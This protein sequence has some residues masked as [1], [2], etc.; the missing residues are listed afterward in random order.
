LESKT[1]VVEDSLFLR[2]FSSQ[3]PQRE[4]FFLKKKK[5]K[6]KKKFVGAI[7]TTRMGICS[8]ILTHA[9]FAQD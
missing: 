7:S 2:T 3:F 6:K 9:K 8:W 1:K 4:S 5:K